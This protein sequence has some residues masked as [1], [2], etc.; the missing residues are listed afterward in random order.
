[1]NAP[2]R[3]REAPKEI[4]NVQGIRRPGEVLKSND[5]THGCGLDRYLQTRGTVRLFVGFHIAQ[6]IPMF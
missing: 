2:F 1:M 6:I 4:P 3:Y 5:D